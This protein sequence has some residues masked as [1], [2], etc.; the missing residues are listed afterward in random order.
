MGKPSDTYR[1]DVKSGKKAAIRGVVTTN[2]LASAIPEWLKRSRR[3]KKPADREFIGKKIRET[4]LELRLG[5]QEGRRIED[6]LGTALQGRL[7]KPEPAARGKHP[8][9]VKKL[10]FLA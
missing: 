1:N 4:C 5:R 2:R 10:R 7:M 9:S 6:L 8:G 3:R